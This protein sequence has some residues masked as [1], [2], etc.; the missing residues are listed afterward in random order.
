MNNSRTNR[1]IRTSKTNNSIFKKISKFLILFLIVFTT[2]GCNASASTNIDLKEDGTGDISIKLSIPSVLYKD[3]KTTDNSTTDNNN[4][5]NS[6]D[7]G[8]ED[9]SENSETT[10][11][12]EDTED[13]EN[14]EN[15]EN[16]ENSTDENKV[17]PL[18]TESELNNLLK[19]RFKGFTIESKEKG[20][21]VNYTISANYKKNKQVQSFIDNNYSIK[22]SGIGQKYSFTLPF[23][24]FIP[25]L[26]SDEDDENNDTSF[27]TSDEQTYLEEND[28]R[29]LSSNVFDLQ[30]LLG[31]KSKIKTSI[32]MP[33]TIEDCNLSDYATQD[34]QTVTI[35]ISKYLKDMKGEDMSNYETSIDITSKQLGGSM[36]KIVAIIC[37][38]LLIFI[39]KSLITKIN[40]GPF[41]D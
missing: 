37:G 22:A 34:G 33:G 35:D 16:T 5:E 28:S 31:K 36:F 25:I 38:V 26:Q 32:T 14:D 29:F 6:S 4:G 19:K 12:V 40:K 9:N 21:H 7:D 27:K 30:D 18:F 2:T 23:D 11:G 1:T 15:I 8:K 39:I 3:E 41:E 10:K 17:V 13:T 24:D 20:N